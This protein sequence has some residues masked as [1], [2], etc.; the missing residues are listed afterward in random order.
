M[1]KQYNLNVDII[2]CVMNCGIGAQE[3]NISATFD[4]L[5]ERT[6]AYERSSMK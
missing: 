4:T 6:C 2:S 1:V 3:K 5:D